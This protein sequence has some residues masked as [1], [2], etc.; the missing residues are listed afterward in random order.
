MSF[1]AELALVEDEARSDAV[2][3]QGIHLFNNIVMTEESTMRSRE[4]AMADDEEHIEVE[5]TQPGTSIEQDEEY[6]DERIA[7][8]IAEMVDRIQGRSRRKFS[9]RCVSIMFS[10]HQRG[11]VSPG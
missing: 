9:D 4:K 10:I 3:I 2:H 1:L 7:R 11:R 8:E 5:E 6:D